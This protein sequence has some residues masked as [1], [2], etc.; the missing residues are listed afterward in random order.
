MDP[1]LFLPAYALSHSA[2]I[3]YPVSRI[4][5]PENL[6]IRASSTLVLE[7]PCRHRPEKE[8][9][10]IAQ[11]STVPCPI[12]WGQCLT[13][14]GEWLGWLLGPMAPLSRTRPRSFIYSE[15]AGSCGW[16]KTTESYRCARRRFL[17]DTDNVVPSRPVCLIFP[18]TVSERVRHIL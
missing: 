3:P 8:K 4:H 7:T 6:P 18:W 9:R 11:Q 1:A 10:P 5:G 14:W 15:G 17:L 16:G 13:Q 2:L 12:S